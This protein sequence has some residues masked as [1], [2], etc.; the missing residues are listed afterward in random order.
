VLPEPLQVVAI[1][2][3]LFDLL[4]IAYLVG[5]SVAS[6]I[7]GVERATQ[8]IDFVVSLAEENV[9]LLVSGLGDDFYAD[10]DLL[11]S[12]IHTESSAN[13]IHLPTM[14][15]VDLFILP[16]K[17]FPLSQMARRLRLPILGTDQPLVCVASAEDMVLQK[18]LWYRMT[19]ERSE[20]QWGDVQGI[21]KI[22]RASLDQEY[23]NVWAEHLAVADLLTS[24]RSDAG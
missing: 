19:G 17:P 9:E 20:R 11:I 8:D 13:I 4:G 1:L 16:D 15:K 2:I 14:I 5:G 6:S 12:A 24:A 21:L 18:L 10:S 23:L 7:L 22:Q 3:K